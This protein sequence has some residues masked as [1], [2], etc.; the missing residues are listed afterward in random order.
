MNYKY[1]NDNKTLDFILPIEP[2]SVNQMFYNKRSIK[3][4]EYYNWEDNVKQHLAFVDFKPLRELFDCNLHY[5][6][7]K[8]IFT[9]PSSILFNKSGSLS[10]K[11]ID[12]TNVEKPL[13]DIIFNKNHNSPSKPNL[14]LD[15]KYH[16]DYTSCRRPSESH[17]I[18]IQINLKCLQCLKSSKPYDLLDKS[19]LCDHDI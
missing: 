11:A 19:Q 2:F 17:S 4:T 18:L 16:N 1:S 7:T 9:F 12:M 5:F 13:I 6:S 3:T 14:N 15:D 8:L 10:S